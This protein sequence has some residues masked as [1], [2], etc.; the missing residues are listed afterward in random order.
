MS[1]HNLWTQATLPKLES[2]QWICWMTI[3]SGPWLLLRLWL[4]FLSSLSVHKFTSNLVPWDHQEPRVTMCTVKIIMNAVT[5]NLCSMLT[6]RCFHCITL[7]WHHRLKAGIHSPLQPPRPHPSS[8]W[9]EIANAHL[10][11]R[12]LFKSWCLPALPSEMCTQSLKGS[13]DAQSVFP[14]LVFVSGVGLVGASS[15]G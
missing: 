15:R 12:I 10:G 9:V 14:V 5:V 6:F 3:T 1:H 7:G 4:T 11:R 8:S 13:H 2:L